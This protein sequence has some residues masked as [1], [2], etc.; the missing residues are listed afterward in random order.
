MLYNENVQKT[1]NKNIKN[2]SISNFSVN[3]KDLTI[4]TPNNVRIIDKL[5]FS[6]LKGDTLAI[7]GDEGVGKTCLLKA[8]SNILPSSFQI[9]GSIIV[10]KPSYLSQFVEDIWLNTPPFEYLFKKIP[11]Q[12][13]D[14]ENWNRY[15]EVATLFDKMQIDMDTF[16][17][18]NKTLKNLSGGELKKIQL[19]KILLNGADVL[20]LDEPTNHLDLDTIIWLE[21]FLNSF[22]GTTILVSHDEKFLENVST[23]ILF[24]QRGKRLEPIYR[25]SGNGYKEFLREFEDE[26]LRS[27]QDIEQFEKEK[28]RLIKE[29]S[30]ARNDF[31]KRHNKAKP[32]NA[33]EKGMVSHG[34][35]K[36]MQHITR[37]SAKLLSDDD[38]P[39]K[40]ELN[41]SIRLDIPNECK[42]EN[43]KTLLNLELKELKVNDIV[44]SKNVKLN[45]SG[46]KKIVIIGKNGSGKST[47]IKEVLKHLNEHS[48][49]Q[50][51]VGYLPQDYQ[52]TLE[53]S[54]LTPTKFLMEVTD[55]V[56]TIKTM[57]ARM[58]I[59]RDDMEKE[60]GK[61]SGGQKCK[62]L[63][64]KL[65]LQKINFLILDEPTN[66][67]Y[68]LSNMAFRNFLKSF[69]GAALIVS[70]D[71]MMISEVADEVYKLTKDGL[72]LESKK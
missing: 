26:A 13:F 19:A 40:I 70:H 49:S 38:K 3:V 35:K 24:L 15:T 14:E 52:E 27:E 60:I 34:E 44:L 67:L 63:I 10:N 54:T 46:P 6:A 11:N 20:L 17:E 65:L 23:S 55:D 72:K 56:T 37:K 66:N 29:L 50:I 32:Q 68:P 7:I 22:D 69:L 61:L 5:S 59:K 47:L 42:I 8:I 21:K 41:E 9:N 36:A 62:I 33:A 30:D 1:N 2:V 43:G 64:T 12:T 25:F 48:D 58:N 18:D 45:L 57:L 4:L 53:H 39:E 51:R 16:F 31:N 28:K 71:R